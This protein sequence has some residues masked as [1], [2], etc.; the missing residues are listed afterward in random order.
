M[1]QGAGVDLSVLI[2]VVMS[3]FRKIVAIAL[4]A[5]APVSAHEFWISPQSYQVAPGAPLQADLRVGQNMGGS[6]YA[7]IPRNFRQFELTMGGRTVPVKGRAGDRP[8]LNM[9]VAGEGLVIVSHV[10]TDN[11]LTYHEKEKFEAFI[12]HKNF[13]GLMA[14]HKE[15]GLPEEG[16]RELYSRYAKSLMAVGHGKGADKRLGLLTEIVAGANPYTDPLSKGLP[17][18]VFYN[19][20]PR[21]NVQVEVFAKSPSGKVTITHTQT[22]KN[23][24]ARVAVKSGY[25]YL[26]DSVVMRPLSQKSATDPVW[27]SLWASLT[28]RVP[29]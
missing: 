13:V 29:K 24:R 7:F 4:L 1:S 27:E 6:V 26:V 25:E 20:K 12:E 8:A 22:D 15:R 17:V 23:G 14:Q 9:S 5:A 18:Q 3:I 19:G 21:S 11:K 16:F 2:G 10:T 28:F